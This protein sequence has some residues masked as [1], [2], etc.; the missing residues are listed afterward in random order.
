[1]NDDLLVEV[2]DEPFEL[3]RGTGNVWVDFGYPDAELRRL[4]TIAAVSIIGLLD[5]GKITARAAAEVTGVTAAD[6]SRI[7]NTDLSRFTLDRLIR[8][9]TK[10]DA[11]VTLIV[12]KRAA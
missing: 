9:L 12:G 3:V 10:L 11:T 7:R 8:I 2:D 6:I 5:D 4:K 1:M